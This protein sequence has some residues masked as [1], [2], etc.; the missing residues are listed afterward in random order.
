MLQPEPWRVDRTGARVDEDVVQGSTAETTQEW[1]H[2][3]YLIVTVSERRSVHRNS[4]PRNSVRRQTTPPHH[5]PQN[6]TSILDQN[7]EQ[8]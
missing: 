4:L 2:H 6:T 3:W 8:Y 7:H 5:I 1:R